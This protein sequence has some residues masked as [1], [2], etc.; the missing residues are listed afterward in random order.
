MGIATA[1]AAL[2]TKGD[3]IKAEI[4]G[5]LQKNGTVHRKEILSHLKFVGLMGN[6]KD[7]MGSLAAYFSNWRDAFEPDGAGNWRLSHTL[8]A[9]E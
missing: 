8:R 7:P 3:R 6:E 9:A 2:Q 4:T 5:L 1:T